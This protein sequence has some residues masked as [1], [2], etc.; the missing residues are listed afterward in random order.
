[1]GLMVHSLGE[2]PP[3]V[4]RGYY[5]Y[6][7]DYGW[8]EPLSDALGDNFGRMSDLASRR[9]AVVLRGTVGSHFADEVLSWHGVNGEPGEEVLPAIMITTRNPHEFRAP[10]GKA[11]NQHSMVLIPLKGVCKTT[12]DVTD[13]IQRIFADIGEGKD[14]VEFEVVKEQKKGVRGAVVDALTVRPAVGPLALDLK[15][16]IRN[17]SSRNRGA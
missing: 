5:V 2:L 9:N 10:L 6:V 8:K 1:M 14:L 4:A 7:L 13:L 16:L 11:A 17:L 15:Q 12:T 3:D